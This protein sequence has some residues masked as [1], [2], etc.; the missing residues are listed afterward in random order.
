MLE[1][2]LNKV[3]ALNNCSF[4]KKGLQRRCFPVNTA[5]FLRTLLFMEL[6]C[7]ATFNAITAW[8]CNN[9]KAL[10]QMLER[11][12]INIV[13]CLRSSIFLKREN[14]SWEKSF[15]FIMLQVAKLSFN[16]KW[17]RS[18][19]Y[20]KWSEVKRACNIKEIHVGVSFTSDA[21]QRNYYWFV[22]INSFCK[23]MFGSASDDTS[24][25]LENGLH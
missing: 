4:F 8:S 14:V 18:E 16:R 7:W 21:W 19:I 15:S 20:P 25:E 5:K 6:C 24:A 1:S 11:H 10:V 13:N 17:R 2:L 23:I 12:D 3:E 9:S 22:E